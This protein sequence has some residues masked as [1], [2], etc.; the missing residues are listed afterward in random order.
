M[1]LDRRRFLS[2]LTIMGSSA[3]MPAL[4]FAQADALYALR[5][6][7]GEPVAN[8]QLPSE[9]S[10]ENLP[11]IIHA[12][13]KNPDVILIEFFDYN[14]PF[15]H[16]AAGDLDALLESDKNLQLGLVNNAILSVG[17]VQTAKV[18]QAVLKH[19]GP[20]QAYAFH[21]RMFKRRGT[22]DGPAA[23][24][25]VR[26]MGLDAARI[27]A[28]GDSDSVLAVLQSHRKLAENLG[29]STTPSFDL[30]GVGILGYPGPHSI[31]RMTQAVRSCDRPLC[32]V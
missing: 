8:Y 30:N 27:E 25:V 19:Y 24:G 16:K 15:C 12:G 2:R 14:C 6:D 4:A 32:P 21:R 28:S 26:D 17:S 5:G 10:T 20:L 18:Q 7:N 9:L 23:L 29:F 11:G 3:L 31:R 22:N 13:A 1:L